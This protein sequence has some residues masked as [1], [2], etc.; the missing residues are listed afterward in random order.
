MPVGWAVAIVALWVTVAC[1]IV[2]VIGALRQIASYLERES[3]GH[4]PSARAQPEPVERGPLGGQG[5]DL[6]T[7]LPNLAAR[8]A[9]GELVGLLGTS[10]LPRLLVFLSSRCAPCQKLAAEMRSSDPARLASYLTVV[11][12]PDDA[13]SLELPAGLPVVTLAAHEI[14]GD[15]GIPGR[16]FVLAVDE[17]GIVRGKQ[18]PTTVAQLASFANSAVSVPI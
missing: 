14:K 16:P 4:A 5:P 10:D 8:D 17:G 6:G 1:L 12:D 9:N 2:V 3:S 7:Q 18:V 11:A 13:D 15:L